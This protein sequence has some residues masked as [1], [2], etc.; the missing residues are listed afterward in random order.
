V[1]IGDMNMDRSSA[2]FQAMLRVHNNLPRQ[3]PG[4]DEITAKALSML[5]A[6]SKHAK[7]VDAGCGPGRATIVLA[8]SLDATILALDLEESFL[9]IL[10]QRACDLGLANRIVTRV[11]DMAKLAEPQES[12]DLIWSEGAVY[13]IGFDKALENWRPLLKSNGIIACTELSW[14]T[15]RPSSEPASF[16]RSSYPGMRS[17]EANIQSAEK[18]GYCCINNFALP[19]SCWWDEYY[20]PMQ[21]RIDSLYSE[22]SNNN[23]LARAIDEANKEISL[24][25]KYADQYGYVFYLLQKA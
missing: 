11:A 9:H 22:A 17:S 3:G 6:F 2:D 10:E 4:S 7:I 1:K 23:A 13:C 18:L 8:Q 24:Y 14:L 25:E 5:P 16:W 12:I 19:A 15:E 21:K 20:S